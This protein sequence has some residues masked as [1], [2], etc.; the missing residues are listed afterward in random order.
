MN[1][2]KNPPPPAPSAT[3]EKKTIVEEGTALKGAITS[4]CAVLVQGTI[5][6]EV[7]GPSIEVSATGSVEGKITTSNLSSRGKIAGELD[8]E[9]AK[10]SGTI[11]PKSVVRASKL[12]VK[13]A[14]TSG[15]IELRFGKGN[16]ERGDLS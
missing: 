6:G 12:D 8:V 2:P 16:D 13:L 5:S 9:S 3:L 11:A 10:L 7:T 4:T 15:K 14:A 1:N